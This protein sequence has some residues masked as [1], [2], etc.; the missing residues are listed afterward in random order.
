MEPFVEYGSLRNPETVRGNP[1][2]VLGN[3]KTVC[4]IYKPSVKSRNCPWIPKTVGRI[5]KLSVKSR[6]CPGNPT[7][8]M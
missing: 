4:R 8:Y 3:P 7:N 1:E 5:L 2:A 6:N